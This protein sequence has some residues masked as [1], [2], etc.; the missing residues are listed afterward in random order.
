[1]IGRGAAAGAAV[2]RQDAACRVAGSRP[3]YGRPPAA[4]APASPERGAGATRAVIPFASPVPTLLVHSLGGSFA[5]LWPTLAADCGLELELVADVAD[6]ERRGAIGL[7]AAGGEEE[8]LP[9]VVRRAAA[10]CPDVAA[11]GA[12]PSHRV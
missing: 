2:V 6:F 4:A 7:V 9:G 3:T 12:L 1:M 11:V 8:A 10:L 5:A